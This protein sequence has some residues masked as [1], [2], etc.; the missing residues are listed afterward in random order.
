M[1]ITLRAVEAV[2]ATEASENIG[3]G[4]LEP[5]NILAQDVFCA[6]SVQALT[7]YGVVSWMH[8]HEI[9]IFCPDPLYC[10]QYI[11]KVSVCSTHMA[12]LSMR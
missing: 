11:H 10:T 8:E 5:Q 1:L 2:R 7:T 6:C 12:H 3:R 4:A 9:I